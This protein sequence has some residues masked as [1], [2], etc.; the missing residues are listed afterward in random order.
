MTDLSF[1]MLNIQSVAYPT[2]GYMPTR[3]DSSI[4]DLI[5][6]HTAG[7]LS[8]SAID[9]DKEHRAI[10]DAM[11]AYNWVITSD[12]Q[13]FVGRPIEYISA[14]TFGRNTQSVSVVVVGNFQSNDPGYNGSPLPLELQAL[15]ELCLYAHVTIPTIVRTIGHRDVAPLFYPDNKGDY[16]T[17]CPG[18][19]LYAYIPAIKDFILSQHHAKI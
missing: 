18:D 19:T 14:A 8:Q 2:P 6:H 11:I 12:G 16:S 4:T 9:I 15:R 5:I 1:G 3:T 17:A 7:S 10:G 13:A